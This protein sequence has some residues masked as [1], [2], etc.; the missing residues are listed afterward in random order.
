MVHF[1]NFRNDAYKIRDC[2]L[3]LVYLL[4]LLCDFCDAVFDPVCLMYLL[5]EQ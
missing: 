3:S 5:Y 4:S 2:S 1:L